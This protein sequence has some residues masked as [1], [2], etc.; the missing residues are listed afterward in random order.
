ME[1]PIVFMVMEQIGYGIGVD[2]MPN[3]CDLE[4]EA[5]QSLCDPEAETTVRDHGDWGCWHYRRLV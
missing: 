3:H 2:R 4:A 5:A 1:V